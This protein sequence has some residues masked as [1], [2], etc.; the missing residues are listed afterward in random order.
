MHIGVT[1]DIKVKYFN[2]EDDVK[3]KNLEKNILRKLKGHLLDA[4]TFFQP[5]WFRR[6]V[7]DGYELDRFLLDYGCYI[8][9]RGGIIFWLLYLLTSII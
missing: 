3:T 8:L 6:V 2:M 7:Q 9:F 1:K 4:S 5:F